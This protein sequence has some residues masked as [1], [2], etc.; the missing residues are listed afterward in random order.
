MILLNNFNTCEFIN[1]LNGERESSLN[2]AGKYF[3]LNS[4]QLLYLEKA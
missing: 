3:L 2:F 1:W 4:K